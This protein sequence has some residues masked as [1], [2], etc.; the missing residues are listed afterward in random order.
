MN[1]TKIPA[2]LQKYLNKQMLQA[3]AKDGKLFDFNR[4]ID[5]A[6]L[7]HVTDEKMPVTFAMSHDFAGGELVEPHARC[8]VTMRSSIE[9][10]P[11]TL[12]IDM[13]FERYDNLPTIDL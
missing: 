11:F 6:T 2:T 5:D 10:E 7:S 13:T 9:G 3:I 4:Q 8:F 12:T 1:S